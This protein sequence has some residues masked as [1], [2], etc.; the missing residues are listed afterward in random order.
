MNIQH[1]YYVWIGSN[2]SGFNAVQLQRSLKNHTLKKTQT[3]TG[4]LSQITSLKVM[5]SRRLSVMVLLTEV[6]CLQV[7]HDNY[8]YRAD[9][10]ATL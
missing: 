8:P 2:H 5:T 6:Q 7:R 4:K 10:K 3:S 9:V 1:V